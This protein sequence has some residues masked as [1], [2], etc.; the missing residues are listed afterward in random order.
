MQPFAYVKE[1]VKKSRFSTTVSLYI[2]NDTRNGH[3]WNGK[4]N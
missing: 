4:L 2:G 1:D 3:S